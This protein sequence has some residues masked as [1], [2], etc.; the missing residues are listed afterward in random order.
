MPPHSV[1]FCPLQSTGLVQVAK[2]AEMTGI[3]LWQYANG[4]VLFRSQTDSWYI[5]KGGWEPH[6]TLSL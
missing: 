1:V 2:V 5:P 4:D 6:T 3:V